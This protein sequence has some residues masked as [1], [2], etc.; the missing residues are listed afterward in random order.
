MVDLATRQQTPV[1]TG[2][3]RGDIVQA[4]ADGRLLI[5]QSNQVD[6]L[7]PLIAPQVAFTNPAENGVAALPLGSVQITFDQ[8]MFVGGDE[9]SGSVVNSNLYALQGVDSGTVQIESVSYDSAGQTV[10]LSFG[11][12]LP[13]VYTLTVDADVRSVQGIEMGTDFIASF[14]AVSDFTPFVDF[15]FGQARSDRTNQTISYDASLINRAPFDLSLPALLVVNPQDW[16]VGQPQ[17]SA[18]PSGSDLWLLDLSDQLVDGRLRPGESVTG[19][20]ITV[21]NPEG[22]RLIFEYGL[23]TLPTVNQAPLFSS[24]PVVNAVVDEGYTYQAVAN[25]PDGISIAYLLVD[26]PEGMSLD[27]TTGQITWTPNQDSSAQ[28]DVA[29]RAYDTRGGFAEQSFTIDV[30][31]GNRAPVIET[32]DGPLVGSENEPMELRIGASDPDGDPIVM[33]VENLP[34]GAR[35]DASINTIRWTPGFADAGTYPGITIVATDGRLRTVSRTEWL[36]EP[37]NQPPQVVTP[38]AITVRQGETVRIGL[39][40]SDADRDDLTFTSSFLPYGATLDP[41]TGLFTWPVDFT[42]VGQYEIPITVDDGVD[43]TELTLQVTALNEN[44]APRTDAVGQWVVQEG[45]TVRF[46]VFANDPDR[47]GTLPPQRDPSGELIETQTFGVPYTIVTSA[48]N[49]PPGSTFDL[50]TGMFQ[51]TPGFDAAG[52]YTPEFTS[53]DDGD[54]TGLPKSDIVQVPITVLNTNRPPVLDLI[55]NVVLRRGDVIELPIVATDADGNPL[56]LAASGLPGYPLPSFMTFVDDGS[57]NGRLS[58]APE[59]NHRGDYPI[60]LIATDNGDGNPRQIFR[61]TSTFVVSVESPNEPPVLSTIGDSV[62]VVGQPIELSLR[63]TDLDEDA[64]TFSAV[65]LPAGAT[66]TPQAIYG[67][68]VFQWTPSADDVGTHTMTIRVEDSG[69]GDTTNILVAE[70]TVNLIVKLTNTAPELQSI[71]TLAVAEQDVLDVQLT[72]TDPDGDAITYRADDLPPGAELDALSGRLRWTPNLFQAGTYTVQFSATDGHLSD[73]E[74]VSIVIANNNQPPILTPLPL[75]TGLEDEALQFV[76]NADD[77]EGEPILLRSPSLPAGAQLDPYTGAFTWTPTFAQAGS[78]TFPIEATDGSGGTDTIEV[79]LT[80]ANVNRAPTV[81]VSNRAVTIGQTLDFVIDATDLDAD[82]LTFSANGLP[83]GATL[84]PSSGRLTWTPGAGQVGDYVVTYLVSDG[85]TSASRAAILRASLTP[86]VPVVRIELTPSFPVVPGQTVQIRSSISSFSKVADRAIYINGQPLVLDSRGRGEFIPAAS[87]KYTVTATATNIQGEKGQAETT[88]KVRAGID[89]EAPSVSLATNLDRAIIANATSI[90]GTATDANL[91]G[92]KLELGL[93]GGKALQTVGSGSTSVASSVLATIDPNRFRSGLYRLRL[94]ATDF[95]GRQSFDETVLEIASESNLNRYTKMQ[96]DLSAALGGEPFELRRSYDSFAAETPESF[97]TGWRWTDRDLQL[98]TDV[99]STGRESLGQFAPYQSGTRLYLTAP[100]GDRIGFTFAPTAESAGGIT[101]YRPNWI[102]DAGGGYQL[103]SA[104]TVLSKSGRRFYELTRALPYHPADPRFDGPAF[105]LIAADGTVYRLNAEGTTEKLITPSGTT[106]VFSDSGIIASNGERIEIARDREGRIVEVLVPGDQPIRY[107]YDAQGRLISAGRSSQQVERYAYETGG[108]GR[109]AIA[110]RRA[111]GETIAYDPTLSL[112]PLQGDVGTALQFNGTIIDGQL[113]AGGTDRYSFHIRPSEL[114]STRGDIVLLS[115]SIDQV[116]GTLAPAVPQIDGLIPLTTRTDATSSFALFAVDSSGLKVVSVLG[117]DTL[118]SGEYTLRIE[119]SGDINADGRVDGTD[120]Q[121]LDAGFG[122]TVADPGYQ[123]AFDLDRDGIVGAADVQ[124]L[125]SNLQFSTN[126]RPDV[127]A[128]STRTH[129]NLELNISLGGLVVDP[130]GDAVTL[131]IGNVVGGTATVVAGQDVRF[132]PS[133]GFVGTATIEVAAHDGYNTSQAA[134]IS[135]D[136]SGAPLVGIDFVNRSPS[137]TSGGL[138]RVAAVGDFADQEDVPLPDSYVTFVS[139]DP[140]VA[141]VDTTGRIAPVNSGTTVLTVEA[142]GLRASTPLNVFDA[143]DPRPNQRRIDLQVYPESIALPDQGGTRQIVLTANGSFVQPRIPE[144]VFYAVSDPNVVE[145]SETGLITSKNPGTAQVTIIS[146]GTEQRIDVTVDTPVSGPAVIGAEGGVVRG[147]DGSLLQVPAGVLDLPQ[148]FGIAPVSLGDLPFNIPAEV[149]NVV[150]AIDLQLGDQPLGVPVQLAVPMP[151]SVPAGTQLQIYRLGTV[152]G[153][154]GND[155]NALL[156]EDVAVVGA[157]GIARTTSPP[158]AGVDSSDGVR[159]FSLEGCLTAVMAGI[160]STP[161]PP[162]A[163]A[164]TKIEYAVGQFIETLSDSIWKGTNTDPEFERQEDQ[165][166]LTMCIAPQPITV[167]A[168]PEVGEASFETLTVPIT[169]GITPVTL[170]VPE[171]NLTQPS[172]MISSVEI[173]NPGP[174]A[175]LKIHGANLTAEG[176]ETVKVVFEA[177]TTIPVVPDGDMVVEIPDGMAVGTFRISVQHSI[178]Q[179]THQYS[180]SVQVSPPFEQVVTALFQ[181]DKVELL[182]LSSPTSPQRIQSIAVGDAPYGVATTPDGSR[183]YVT[184]TYLRD[185]RQGNIS[186]IDPIAQRKIATIELSKTSGATPFDIEIDPAGKFAFVGD[187]NRAVLYI[188]DI[189]SNSKTFHQ[190]IRTL[191]LQQPIQDADSDGESAGGSSLSIPVGVRGMAVTSDGETLL[192]TV[193]T[194]IRPKSSGDSN[195]SNGQLFLVDI[196]PNR[197]PI[198]KVVG[199]RS[200]EPAVSNVSVVRI[201]DKTDQIAIANYVSADKRGIEFSTYSHETSSLSAGRTVNLTLGSEQDTFDVDDARNV[202]LSPDG[203]YAFVAGFAYFD[204]DVP[205]RV[206]GSRLAAGGVFSDLPAG[207][208]I[209]V[210]DVEGGKL[211]GATRP[212]D[213][214]WWFEMELSPDG[215]YLFVNSG[216][217]NLGSSR[218]GMFIYDAELLIQTAIGGSQEERNL[219]PLNDLN[220]AID[221]KSGLKYNPETNKMEP[222]SGRAPLPLGRSW[223]LDLQR[224]PPRIDVS[225][226]PINLAEE[227]DPEKLFTPDEPGNG[228]TVFGRYLKGIDLVNDFVI[229]LNDVALEDAETFRITI[230]GNLVMLDGKAPESSEDVNPVDEAQTL[231]QYDVGL[232]DGGEHPLVIQALDKNSQPI[233]TYNGTIVVEDELELDFDAKGI[234]ETAPDEEGSATETPYF[235]IEDLRFIETLDHK[236]EFRARL[237]DLPLP[238]VYND[239]LKLRFEDRDGNFL[240][241]QK[242]LTFEIEEGM[243]YEDAF[244]FSTADLVDLEK[245]KNLDPNEDKKALSKPDMKVFVV[246]TNSTNTDAFRFN[247]SSPEQ[248]LK[249]ELPDWIG[250]VPKLDPVTNE[251]RTAGFNLG[252]SSYLIELF[253]PD[254]LNHELFGAEAE[255]VKLFTGIDLATYSKLGLDTTVVIPW[256]V[257]GKVEAEGDKLEADVRLFGKQ[258]IEGQGAL[259][260]AGLEL[261]LEADPITLGATFLTVA[262]PERSILPEELDSLSA[263][264]PSKYSTGFKLFD[265]KYGEID[266]ESGELGPKTMSFPVA[267]VAG[268]LGLEVELGLLASLSGYVVSATI[269]AQM[270]L[271]LTGDSPTFVGGDETYLKFIANPV[272]AAQVDA[273]AA[274]NATLFGGLFEFEAASANIKGSALAEVPTELTVTYGSQEGFEVKAK[275]D[276]LLSAELNFGAKV[277]WDDKEIVSG[278]YSWPGKDKDGNDKPPERINIFCHNV[279]C[280]T[281]EN[282]V[283]ESS[284]VPPANSITTPSGSDAGIDSN[285]DPLA[286]VSAQHWVTVGAGESDLVQLSRVDL[287]FVDLSDGVLATYQSAANDP[288]TLLLSSD[289]AGHGWFIDPTP[290][291][292]EEFFWDSTANQYVAIPGG[293]AD[294]KVDLVTTILHEQGHAIGLHHS[295]ENPHSLMNH[296]LPV[297]V[298]RLP[299]ATDLLENTHT[300]AASPHSTALHVAAPLDVTNGTFDTATTDLLPESWSTGGDVRVVGG[301]AMLREHDR[302]NTRL[303]QTFTVPDGTSA[304]QFTIVDAD[305]RGAAGQPGDVFEVALLDADSGE[306]LVDVPATLTQTDAL[307]NAQPTGQVHFGT[308]VRVPNAATSG[309]SVSSLGGSTISVDLSGVPAGTEATLYFDLIGFGDSDSYVVLDDV[310]LLSGEIPTLEFALDP[311]SDSG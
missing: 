12:L 242:D 271:D 133:D 290:E 185:S 211:L 287:E 6:V 180:N 163:P 24:Q 225:L 100:T 119:I 244:E 189:D 38:A 299:H 158:F 70:E 301:A 84:D 118:G 254:Q 252:S 172:P 183:T 58:I 49:L 247:E 69:N 54:Q 261:T 27:T 221:V 152:P 297:G 93:L 126:Q 90:L 75:Q 63:V 117:S 87:G 98:Q 122:L 216:G 222:V 193:P 205:S 105:E 56:S 33:W 190:H 139:S 266:P 220:G 60:T 194:Q 206:H 26:A 79:S 169:K 143:D 162:L 198:G 131:S 284:V 161:N 160:L 92:W 304:L 51:W 258:L 8:A 173:L 19:K 48:S 46:Q 138:L 282:L 30:D 21:D 237:I 256:N 78:Y 129:R 97:G 176:T 25:D 262:L 204:A 300:V 291:T 91:D 166:A 104:D 135:I 82:T 267:T 22:Q 31:G 13:D 281:E 272:F 112:T 116:S 202:I 268:I 311:A 156:Q 65:G 99:N 280:D 23:Y 148:T 32:I 306:P 218:G 255:A 15:E 200:V 226:Q 153:P 210:V 273:R 62:A 168:V 132:V 3:T 14:T 76:V 303:S 121:L 115:V 275:S 289:A 182:S 55:D 215:K 110:Q 310:R 2:G 113:A 83:T 245:G 285:L 53:T 165:V 57:G 231:F 250:E 178:G 50:E 128:P 11:A 292:A 276:L 67:R 203:K 209:G 191:P 167:I 298:R 175:K 305:L 4:T 164:S 43:V 207:S 42:Q 144:N 186:V 142:E 257:D 236:V 127:A 45:Q 159:V 68:A 234:E 235:E 74:T 44:A 101:V 108:Q 7:Q 232:L 302:S 95:D 86:E 1:A 157:D 18:R 123:L 16:F 29:V 174:G 309:D 307:L 223:G 151:A 40:A 240:F 274:I 181:E 248:I 102:A 134:A 71:G 288:G 214:G 141:V 265:F 170:P 114:N 96:T 35:F 94:T 278:T 85:R 229:T 73:N 150:G 224:I 217:A 103:R 227:G 154:D 81:Q 251:E 293:P 277:F 253:M 155:R 17:D 296:S 230:G 219:K 149:T 28:V 188:V 124:I 64:L 59:A 89:R 147:S 294:G 66:L 187:R 37:V 177:K 41:T 197:K 260:D 201:D 283:L 146:G 241:D 264:F 39:Q 263:P 239:N 213:G 136:V 208:T 269:A 259:S 192:V 145:V 72:A 179:S 249:V 171:L 120:G 80:I 36:I 20:T 243:S 88:L 184:N 246:P 106:F 233:V 47:P 9:E 77:L 52:N 109:L 5:S 195:F 212:V 295:G 34:A 137:L 140:D 270:K 196:R 130:E 10:V 238:E 286:T 308:N 279:S 61:D 107:Q 111:G 228:A 199:S 125:G